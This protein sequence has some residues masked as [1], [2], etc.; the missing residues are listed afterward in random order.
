MTQR[1]TDCQSVV[2][3]YSVHI[4]VN[5]LPETF[6]ERV[7]EPVRT[8]DELKLADAPDLGFQNQRFQ[9]VPFRF[10]RQS[11]YEGKTR[12]F[13]ISVAFTTGE[14]KRRHSSTNSST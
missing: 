10:K 9:N 3:P 1:S 11:I 2:L 4:V 5:Q 13:T 7:Q 8:V 6:R 14:Q 12:F